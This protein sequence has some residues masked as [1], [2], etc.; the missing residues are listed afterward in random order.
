[1]RFNYVQIA[2]SLV[3]LSAFQARSLL[4][5]EGPISLLVDNTVLAHGV[6]H[7][8][9][10]ISTGPARWGPHRFE[11]GYLARVPV[12]AADANSREYQNI[13]YLPG[14]AHLARQGHIIMKTSAELEAEKDRQPIGRFS[15]Y[16]WFDFNI[17]QKV[18]IESI[19][20][21]IFPTMNLTFATQFDPAEEQ[22]TSLS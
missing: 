8:T 1:M 16:G 6:T 5:R 21:F 4:K 10:W 20:G 11:G 9:A 2:Q 3:A 7:E 19:D 12:H 22:R 14:I 15:G 13:G 18:P 17:F